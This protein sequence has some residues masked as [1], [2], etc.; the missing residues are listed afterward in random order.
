M[1]GAF[2]D[3]ESLRMINEVDDIEWI[4]TKTKFGHEVRKIQIILIILPG[5]DLVHIFLVLPPPKGGAKRLADILSVSGTRCF[6]AI[7]A[8]H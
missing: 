4:C 1:T 6:L 7:F 8:K 2:K 5:L 3:Q